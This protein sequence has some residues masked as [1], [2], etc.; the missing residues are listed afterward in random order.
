MCHFVTAAIPGDVELPFIARV[1]DKHDLAF[2]LLTSS[3]VV[4]QLRAGDRYVLT[5][6]GHCDCGTALGSRHK[7]PEPE[8]HAR[9]VAKLRKKG[10]GDAKIE[11]WLQEKQATRERDVRK[12]DTDRARTADVERWLAV[13]VDALM[14]VPRVGLVLHFYG[15]EIESESI[16][17]EHERV[18]RSAL[19]AELLLSLREDV[20]YEFVRDVKA[21][22]DRSA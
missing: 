3:P 22:S 8:S 13:V 6:R 21:S 4:P 11:R 12:A 18:P 15:G 16:E 7:T 14:L 5:T 19:T 1:F 17:L 2:R 20:L 10:W 9:Q